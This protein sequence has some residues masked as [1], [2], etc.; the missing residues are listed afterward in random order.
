MN[1]QTKRDIIKQHVVDMLEES[2]RAMI[3]KIDKALNSGAV[4]IDAW[5]PD[6]SPMIL[7]KIIVTAILKNESCQYEGKGTGFEKQIAKEVK[8]LRYFL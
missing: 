5:R 2:Q 6:D 8:N 7:P 1:T 4:D 3:K